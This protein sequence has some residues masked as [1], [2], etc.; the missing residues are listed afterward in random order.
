MN[1]L[2][3]GDV[4]KI[5][6][7][8]LGGTLIPLAMFLMWNTVILGSDA[9]AG[10]LSGSNFDPLQSLMQQSPAFVGPVIGIFSIVAIASSFV[11]FVLG[12]ADFI[13]D[14]LGYRSQAKDPALYLIVL[15]IPLGVAVSYPDL[16]VALLS[17]AG[18]Y[19]VLVLFGILPPLMAYT[20]RR[21]RERDAKSGSLMPLEVPHLVPFGDWT[22]ISLT[23]I[24][25]AIILTQA[26]TGK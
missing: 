24:S 20:M 16:F 22:L 18:T 1:G 21:E 9:G 4:D 14:A 5:R 26:L 23:F 15:G 25:V 11:G 2:Q 7:A 19:G 6:K 17:V 8:I 12:L 10:R 13:A 3:E